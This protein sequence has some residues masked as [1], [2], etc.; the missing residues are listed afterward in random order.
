MIYFGIYYAIQYYYRIAIIDFWIAWLLVI[1]GSYFPD[2][3]LDFGTKFHRSF[4]THS[5]FVPLFFQFV[6]LIKPD[7]VTIELFG[8]F[9]MG[10][11]SHLLL[12][13]LPSSKSFFK[14]FWPWFLYHHTPGDIRGI[15]EKYE[16]PWLVLTGLYVAL[17][18]ALFLSI[19]WKIL[20][21]FFIFNVLL[22]IVGLALAA[23]GLSIY[24]R[25]RKRDHKK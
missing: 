3:D 4:I 2:I 24:T 7:V 10:Y 5:H 15:P 12:D 25:Y 19:K 21:A 17:L 1:F 14:Q 6:Y 22:F 11:S 23:F 13:I 18:S 8:F 9:F 16:R 20:L